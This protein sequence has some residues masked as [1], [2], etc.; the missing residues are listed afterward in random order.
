VPHE[1][2]ISVAIATMLAV[3]ALITDL[4]L[5]KFVV[6]STGSDKPHSLAAVHVLSIGRG[7]VLSAILFVTASATARIFGV[8]DSAGSF[9]VAAFC[10]LIASFA[11]LSIKQIQQNFQFTSEMIAQ[12]VTQLSALA[13]VIIGAFTFRDHRAMLASFLAEAVVYTIASHILAH[14][15]Y[16]LSSNRAVL[17]KAA[18][19]GLPLVINGIGIAALSQFDRMLVGGWLGVQ[20]L[21]QYAVMLALSVY[22]TALIGRVFGPMGTSSLLQHRDT[23]KFGENYALLMFFSGVISVAYSLVVA[24]SLDWLVPIVF[25]SSFHVTQFEHVLIVAIVYF[26]LMRSTAPTMYYLVTAKTGELALLNLTSGIGIAIAFWLLHYRSSL[27]SVL[28]GL[29][30]GDFLALAVVIYMSSVRSVGPR[31]LWHTD[32]LMSLISL[33]IIVGALIWI[34]EPTWQARSMISLLGLFGIAAELAV[35]FYTQRG[36]GLGA[37]RTV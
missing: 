8:P 4:S 19:F 34:P 2:G 9:A 25:G 32:F 7:V 35:G 30:V 27:D 14:T 17:Q 24:L 20:T 29:L 18:I 5:D 12:V 21:G 36:F 31:N 33:T 3:A 6:V 22:P 11:H 10:P 26:R 23:T 28:F 16:G 15:R 37:Q 13:A 1:F